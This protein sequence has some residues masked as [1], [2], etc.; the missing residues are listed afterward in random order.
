MYISSGWLEIFM[1]YRVSWVILH[2]GTRTHAVN[3]TRIHSIHT[4]GPLYI[5]SF[6]HAVGV[7]LHRSVR[8]SNHTFVHAVGVPLDR[9]VRKSNHMFIHAR[10]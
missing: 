8:K 2:E 5:H 1:W 9:S 10:T 7:L 4:Q 3:E 6:I